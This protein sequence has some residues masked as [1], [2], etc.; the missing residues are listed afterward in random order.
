MNKLK[1]FMIMPFEKEFF[2]VYE[3]IKRQLGTEYEFSHAG[4][5]GNQHNILKDIIPPIF[6]ADIVIADLTALNANVMYELGVAH[7][8]NK[9]TIIITQDDL[10]KLPFNLKQYRAKN[11]TA[12]FKKITELTKYLKSNFDGALNDTVAFGN[13]VQD[14][15]PSGNNENKDLLKMSVCNITEA[16]NGLKDFFTENE[17]K[18]IRVLTRTGPFSSIFLVI[19]YK[20]F[21]LYN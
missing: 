20:D 5:E 1:V 2:E 10:G 15:L 17:D 6:N 16:Q 11:Y 12:H 3:E 9:R 18:I 7:T 21:G 14:F 19:F 13:P 8:L 4:D